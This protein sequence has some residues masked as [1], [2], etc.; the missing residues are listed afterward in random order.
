MSTDQSQMLR[1]ILAENVRTIRKQKGL[2]QEDLAD[3]CGIHRTYLGAIERAERNVT[4]NTLELLA[5]SLGI[6]AVDLL[7]KKDSRNAKR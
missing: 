1:K 4:L 6:P 3:I 7:T 5:A 2:S